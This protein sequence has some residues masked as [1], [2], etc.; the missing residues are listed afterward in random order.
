MGELVSVI[1]PAYNASRF[2]RATI[3]SVQAQS[4]KDWE[5]I[6]VDDASDDDTINLLTEI[7]KTEPRLRIMTLEKN[8]GAAVSRNA[9][10]AEARGEYVAFLDSDDLWQ[11]EKLRTQIEFM[12]RRGAAISF[13]A[14]QI[15]RE[16]GRRLGRPIDFVGPQAVGYA[17]MLKK[18]ATMGCSTVMLDWRRLNN[19]RMPLIRT[20]QDYGFWLAL[21]RGGLEA[22]RLGEVMTFYR[23]VQKSIS[24]NKLRKALRQW[25]VYRKL[26]NLPIHYAAWCFGH[27]AV[28]AIVR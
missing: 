10:L 24:R 3:E 20:A 28:R 27:Y 21:M 18:K 15:M 22:H 8:S 26:E 9:A 23:I 7:S 25:Q 4:Y 14:Y 13:T 16:D 19:H 17:D 5:M 6:V 12:R 1:T 2:L 11:P